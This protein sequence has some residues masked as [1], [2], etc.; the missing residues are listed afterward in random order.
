MAAPD[1]ETLSLSDRYST[2]IEQI[3]TDTLKGKIG[4]KEYVYT[5]LTKQLGLEPGTG[6]IF[7]RCLMEQMTQTR[8]RM[9][10]AADALKQSKAQRQLRALGTLEEAWN[11]Y[12]ETQRTQHACSDAA[13]KLIDADNGKR[14]SALIDILD[15]NQTR[16][17]SSKEIESLAKELAQVQEGDRETVTEL[18]QMAAGLKRGVS[19]YTSMNLLGW[20]YEKAQLGF[21]TKAEANNPWGFWAKQ[22]S[23]PLPKQ[24][25]TEQANNQSAFN[26][27]QQQTHLDLS[28]WIELIVL[29]RGIQAGLVGWFDS[30]PYD[31]KAGNDAAAGTFLAF[32]IVW[33]ELSSGFSQ[34]EHLVVSNGMS[35]ACFQV[36]LQI[37]RSFAQRDNFPI[38]GG[39]F[40]S[41]AGKGF[42]DT[43]SYLDR[44]L[45]TIEKTQEKAR[46]LTVLGY[47]QQWL[48][49]RDRA[50]TLHEDALN[51]AREDSDRQCE[52]A[53]LNHL[54][55]LYLSQGDFARAID[56]GQRALLLVRQI[57]DR[58]G[59]VNAI[60]NLGYAEVRRS[61]QQEHVALEEI[62][63]CLER[64]QR[65]IMLLE[66]YPDLVSEIFC[67]LAMG[68][69]YFILGQSN[70]AQPY[71]EKSLA[72]S[73]QLGNL[74]LQG[75]SYANLGEIYY[76]L[77]QLPLAVFHACL[78]LYLLEQKNAIEQRQVANLV[79][80]LKGNLGEDEFKAILERQKPQIVARIGLDGFDYIVE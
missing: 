49:D 38:Y 14:L 2:F 36:S 42:R 37:L 76:Q 69:A 70:S 80:I 50:L 40:A 64:L 67:T 31:R 58:V 63:F 35:D 46:I 20:V 26:L 18:H 75:L 21:T 16:A 32:A 5:Q 8:E 27:A 74:E 9:E 66:K 73:V 22:V 72:I 12:Q 57:G 29:L 55:R 43:L 1:P 44:P 7:E 45:K 6:E 65:G 47:S 68:I 39:V 52:A 25:F 23:S 13:A 19:A 78:G 41:F 48:G 30:Q 79:A 11:R 54:S 24:F 10:A 4:S 71:L 17:F 15:P 56:L 61:Q 60:A 51:L 3:V 34:A 62:E 33:S 53:N 28:A 59:E 77:G